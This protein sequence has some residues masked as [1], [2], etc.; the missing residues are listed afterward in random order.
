MIEEFLNEYKE[1][2]QKSE[3]ELQNQ[4]DQIKT[5][6]KE[7]E[8]FLELLQKDDSDVFT[9]FSPRELA[10]RNNGKILELE[11]NLTVDKEEF[12]RIDSEQKEIQTKLKKIS[13]ILEEE[14]NALK[15]EEKKQAEEENEIQLKIKPEEAYSI[16]M[17]M[18]D[19]L[20]KMEGYVE[21]D[22]KKAKME[23]Q[24]LSS[25]T[26]MLLKRFV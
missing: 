15:E 18:K 5:R 8:K 23:I 20:H 19:T 10:S 26:E 17:E 9:E 4:I 12:I 14:E 7:N 22:P 16:L 21:E 2:L 24:K 3:K 1:E 13:L 11:K 6:I 25:I